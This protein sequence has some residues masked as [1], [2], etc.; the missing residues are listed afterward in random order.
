MTVTSA[1]PS[2]ASVASLGLAGTEHSVPGAPVADTDWVAFRSTVRA[3]RL[4]GVLLAAVDAGA[5]PVTDDQRAGLV[6][7][8]LAAM[9]GALVLERML[10]EVADAFDDR[11]IE[12]RAIKGTAVAHLDYPAPEQRAY[13]DVDVLVRSEQID[14]ATR[15]LADLGLTRAFQPPR[16]GWD[17]RY[18][19]GAMFRATD[20]SEVDLHRTFATPPM[21][22]RIRLDDLW[23]SS[24]PLELGGR[25]VLALDRELR[26][27][28]ACYSAAVADTEPAL[29]TLRDIAQL[30]L[31]DDLD[32]TRVTELAYRWGGRAVLASAVRST[33]TRLRI[34]DV[35]ALSAWAERYRPSE[36]E[37]R[38]LALYQQVRASETA[39]ALATAAMLPTLGSRAAYLWS[40][41]R[42]D[43]AFSRASR[44]TPW[45]R[46]TRAAR[47]L[48]RA[49]RSP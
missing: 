30:A 20:G 35:T 23:T 41:A 31:H 22:L 46:A 36:V 1:A 39:R 11:A 15:A 8:H 14:D 44:R 33:W 18:G 34:G 26:L 42:P 2:P 47:D 17:A 7:D 5:F 25:V 10:L 13:G 40:L 45:Q 43:A 24:Q 37:V 6:Q 27:L 4:T 28:N 21:G 49:R 16:P 9:S 38:E 29:A 32:S 19:K 12:L 3:G 48:R